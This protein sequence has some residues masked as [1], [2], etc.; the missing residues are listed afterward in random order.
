MWVPPCSYTFCMKRA[1]LHELHN[2]SSSSRPPRLWRRHFPRARPLS[3]G[4]AHT[5]AKASAAALRMRRSRLCPTARGA[6]WEC[7]AAVPL[8]T[9]RGLGPAVSAPLGPGGTGRGAARSWR[10]ATGEQAGRALSGWGGV[11]T[12]ALAPRA[13]CRALPGGAVP[14][15]VRSVRR[16]LPAAPAPGAARGIPERGAVQLRAVVPPRTAQRRPSQGGS[17]EGGVQLPQGTGPRGVCGASS[18][19]GSLAEVHVFH[20]IHEIKCYFLKILMKIGSQVKRDL[21]GVLSEGKT[22]R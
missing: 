22:T 1:E 11:G 15:A 10:W 19:Q 21:P 2:P 17:G 20:V 16:G 18:C 3:A 5:G 14:S 6:L 13:F 7:V 4:D 12:V 8:A 9:R